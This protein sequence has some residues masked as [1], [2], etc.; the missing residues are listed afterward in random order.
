MLRCTIELI[1]F[2]DEARKVTLGE[3]L[4]KNDGSGN[5]EIGNYCIIIYEKGM[6]T[7]IGNIKGHPRL[8][9]SSSFLLARAIDACMKL[10]T[11]GK[12]G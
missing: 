7:K 11:G 10:N 1:P 3:V 2:G 5:V 9:H 8:Q 4:I 6:P 12:R